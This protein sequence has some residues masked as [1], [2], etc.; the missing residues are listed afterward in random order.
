MRILGVVVGA[1]LL[2]GA[3]R[4][5]T[6]VETLEK[7]IPPP[8]SGYYVAP[9]APTV[10]VPLTPKYPPPAIIYRGTQMIYVPQ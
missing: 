9:V 10:I 2:M 3:D 8:P 4:P 1:F 7:R 5:P 6:L